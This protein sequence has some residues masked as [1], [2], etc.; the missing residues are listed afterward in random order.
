MG[1]EQH[2]ATG[3][4]QLRD[5]RADRLGLARAG[6]SP[7]E[8]VAGERLPQRGLLLEQQRVPRADRCVRASRARGKRP[9]DAVA[10]LV[11]LAGGRL[12]PRHQAFEQEAHVG[13]QR[14]AGDRLSEIVGTDNG[15]RQALDLGHDHVDRR[16]ALHHELRGG[17]DG[18][19]LREVDLKGVVMQT[20]AVQDPP[21]LSQ[22]DR[23]AA[24]S[25]AYRPSLRFQR[26]AELS[27][28]AI[29]LDAILD[30]RVEPISHD[31][32]ALLSG[33]PRASEVSKTARHFGRKPDRGTAGPQVEVGVL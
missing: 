13:L 10:N 15:D 23:V 20:R 7:D 24:A 27:E 6:R 19:S 9:K 29:E 22:D 16:A 1:D 17:I 11:G 5:D 12:Q 2:R 30:I 25:R 31:R 28:H 26:V 14:R 32:E 3:P 33:A 4:Q 21:A 8:H 18:Q